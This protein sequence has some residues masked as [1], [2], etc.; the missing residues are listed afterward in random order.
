MSAAPAP[1][2]GWPRSATADRVRR[3][4]LPGG[5]RLPTDAQMAD[6][7]KLTARLLADWSQRMNLVGP[8]AMAEFWLRHAYDSAQLLPARAQGEGMG[9]PCAGR[10]RFPGLVLATILL[11]GRAGA[12]VH[13]RGGARG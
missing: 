13:S 3:G 8:S 10:R 5:D 7:E 6:L 4:S 9:R 2:D 1:L 11:K 12:T